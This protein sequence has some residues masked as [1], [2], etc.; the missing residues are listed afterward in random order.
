MTAIIAVI[1]IMLGGLASGSFYLPLKY[2][3]K[4]SWES[5]WIVQGFSAWILAPWVIA[6]LTVPS[7]FSII[8]QSPSDSIYLPILFGFGWG[9]GG[10]AWGLS[11]RYLGIGLGNALP[12]GLTSALSTVI[13]PLVP[14]L[15]RQTEV[16]GSTGEALNEQLGVMF[17]G[18]GGTLIIVSI[19]LSL[20][21][22]GVCGW[23]A[24]LKERDVSAA[25]SKS[26]FN[27]KKGLLVAL[28]A[29]VMSAFFSFGESSGRAMAEI[30]GSM[31]QGTIWKYNGVYAVLLIGGFSANAIY[32]IFLAIKNKS[33]KDFT[34]VSVPLLKNY[35]FSLLSGV[36]WYAQFVFKG[37]GTTKIP[38]SIDFIAW[39]VLFSSVIVFSNIIG[40]IIGEWKGVS[41]KARMIL[42]TGLLFLVGSV[43]MVGIASRFAS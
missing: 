30:T 17:L 7:L 18:P 10:L 19:I 21:G 24:S 22:I 20:T 6:L 8:E 4:W 40:L 29:G 28:I 42:V 32:V 2:V 41:L 31:N 15:T 16:S 33:Y 1:L 26:D 37:I 35:M 14:I 12:L 11:I 9:I 38:A 43:V 3:R 39:T 36:L 23:A 13:S 27:L 5:G 25:S 34:A